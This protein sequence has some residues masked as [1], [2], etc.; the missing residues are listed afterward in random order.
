MAVNYPRSRGSSLG[1]IILIGGTF[2][3]LGASGVLGTLY[4]LG[5]PLPYL[6]RVEKAEKPN[7]EGQIPVL[8]AGRTIPAYARVTR[9]D[10]FDIKTNTF[11]T[12]W[13]R[14]QDIR[15]EMILDFNQVMGRVVRQEKKA[16]FAFTEKDFFPVGTQP[17]IT[18]A[19]PPGKRSFVFEAEKVQG[20]ASLKP[21]DHFDIVASLQLNDKPT[22]NLGNFPFPVG[23]SS[24]A[25]TKKAIVRPVV[26]NGT[27]LTPITTREISFSTAG[28]TSG[29]QYKNRPVREIT[30]ALDPSEVA[31]L[32]EALAVNAMLT[33]V[34][35][36]GQPGG[37]NPE[38]KLPVQD[39]LETPAPPKVTRVET[40]LNGKKQLIT[41]PE[42]PEVSLP[43]A[44]QAP[45]PRPTRS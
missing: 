4:A 19:I 21:G 20:M 39:E 23:T 16:G 31:A 44:E 35:R 33:C 15:P 5:V 42:S 17:G 11:S 29:V 37:E 6:N 32:T 40:I 12:V 10:I 45:P 41:F 1:S 2:L 26:Q 18:A 22:G 43:P 34:A 27:V 30:I 13:L 24:A 38:E 14:Q 36:S 28:L 25:Q 7:R 8:V 9:D 3:L